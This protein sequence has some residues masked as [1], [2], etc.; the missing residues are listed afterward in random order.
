MRRARE[1][2]MRVPDEYLVDDEVLAFRDA[3]DAARNS[4]PKEL[5]LEIRDA[6]VNGRLF[7]A[8]S[9]RYSRENPAPFPANQHGC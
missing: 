8:G 1:D 3:Y 5:V 4:L 2:A 6:C 9:G 7:H